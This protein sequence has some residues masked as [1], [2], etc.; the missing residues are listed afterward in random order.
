M[1]SSCVPIIF[2]YIFYVK[3]VHLLPENSKFYGRSTIYFLIYKIT[4]TIIQKYF[5]WLNVNRE[6]PIERAQQR[7]SVERTQQRGS[8][9]ET[10]N[11]KTSIE[12]LQQRDSDR[13]T[14]ILSQG[15]K[16]ETQNF[17]RL[18]RAGKSK[19]SF[20]F[21]FCF[22]FPLSSTQS[23]LLTCES[24]FIPLCHTFVFATHYVCNTLY[25]VG[26]PKRQ[27]VFS[28]DVFCKIKRYP[29]NQISQ[30]F[31]LACG[32]QKMCQKRFC[33]RSKKD[34]LNRCPKT[35]VKKLC[36]TK[37]TRKKDHAQ[38]TKH[39]LQKTCAKTKLAQQTKYALKQNVR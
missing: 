27:M 16:E 12:S 1:L 18:R 9:R 2:L 13:E 37:N 6:Y 34:A 23:L 19:A 5:H 25:D 20:L 7:N 33:L 24:L 38:Q 15:R 4:N 8:N 31:S 10:R 11:R 26:G 21:S 32:A 17:F 39:A 30:K 29:K 35:C 3:Y 22:F 14:P 28:K 36:V